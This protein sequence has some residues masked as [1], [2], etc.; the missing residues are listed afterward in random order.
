[1]RRAWPWIVLLPSVWVGL[2]ARIED[3]FHIAVPSVL[4]DALAVD[5][6]TMLEIAAPVILDG[7]F[8]VVFFC[9]PE[10]CFAVCSRRSRF[11]AS[12]W[13]PLN[14]C[15]AVS[16]ERPREGTGRARR[17]N[18]SRIIDRTPNRPMCRTSYRTLDLPRTK[19]LTDRSA[20]SWY[21][22]S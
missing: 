14:N 16:R 12:G 20:M 2:P 4:R 1:M 18:T 19:V 11:R 9:G 6:P 3:V 17:E 8:T 5:A 7:A 13:H 10:P 21:V 22:R 15:G